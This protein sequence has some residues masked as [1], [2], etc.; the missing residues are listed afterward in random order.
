MLI[1]ILKITIYVR[2]T[3]AEKLT[4]LEGNLIFRL[5]SN[6]PIIDMVKYGTLRIYVIRI[7]EIQY[8]IQYNCIHTEKMICNSEKIIQ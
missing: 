5:S 6:P 1:N 3:T 7:S 8:E 2:W 4:F